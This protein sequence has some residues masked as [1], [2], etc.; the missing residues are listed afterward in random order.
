MEE[1]VDARDVLDANAR[2]CCAFRAKLLG[3]F[4]R[5]GPNKWAPYRFVP[6]TDDREM[7]VLPLLKIQ[8]EAEGAVFRIRSRG[9]VWRAE[10]IAPDTDGDRRSQF[11]ENCVT[12]YRNTPARGLKAVIAKK[13]VR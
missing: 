2:T 6:A 11:L 13:L 9:R 5:A 7:D 3:H 1:T 10:W 8:I 4:R 12:P